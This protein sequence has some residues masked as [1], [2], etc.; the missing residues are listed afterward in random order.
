MGT[1]GWETS[2]VHPWSS[3][4]FALIDAHGVIHTDFF[5]EDIFDFVLGVGAELARLG[6]GPDVL[7]SIRSAHPLWI[8]VRIHR[9]PWFCHPWE[10][11][12]LQG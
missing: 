7:R 8:P 5:V 2:F 9:K 11:R 6:F 10:I 12:K 1:H 3:G 4:S